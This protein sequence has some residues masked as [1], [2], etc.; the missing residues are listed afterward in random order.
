MRRR[1][2]AHPTPSKA[3]RG[4]PAPTS[5]VGPT[6]TPL[7]WS[8]Q[9]TTAPL[10]GPAATRV[11]TEQ[12]EPVVRPKV[13]PTRQPRRPPGSHHGGKRLSQRP[14]RNTD[15][16]REG[17]RGITWDWVE[18]RRGSGMEGNKARKGKGDRGGRKRATGHQGERERAKA[19]QCYLGRRRKPGAMNHP[20]CHSEVS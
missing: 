18:G 5:V 12:G 13:P 8:P 20:L 19:E 4:P 15:A 14:I 10:G 11:A 3:P 2:P 16:I 1:S 7:Y 17:E 9:L 6:Q